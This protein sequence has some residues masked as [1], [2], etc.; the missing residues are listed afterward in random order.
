MGTY[1]QVITLL[2]L[3]RSTRFT[4]D[5]DIT[6]QQESM[7]TQTKTE[8][9]THPTKGLFYA[10]LGWIFKKENHEFA[11][12]ELLK[13]KVLRSL[14]NPVP[15]NY[16]LLILLNLMLITLFTV[17]WFDGRYILASLNASFPSVII[18]GI[19]NVFGHLPH[20]RI[21]I[22]NRSYE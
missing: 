5:V 21:N 11:R 10:F 9:Y 4:R 19:V 17:W 8:M 12:M 1:T 22:R 14:C 7:H 6:T 13:L 2:R 16:V 15:K 20:K 18:S 3:S